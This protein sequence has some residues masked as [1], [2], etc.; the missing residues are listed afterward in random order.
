V[1]IDVVPDDEL[2]RDALLDRLRVSEQKRALAEAQLAL[3][4]VAKAPTWLPTDG[5][6]A[7][8]ADQLRDMAP[9]IDVLFQTAAVAM[10]LIAGDSMILRANQVAADTWGHP[11][12]DLH[13]TRTID[14]TIEEDT[15]DTRERFAHSERG[16]FQL[17][18]YRRGDGTPFRALAMGWPL[19]DDDGEV[20]CLIGVAIPLDRLGASPSILAEMKAAAASGPGITTPA[21]DD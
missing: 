14:L 4:K 3:S 9:A 21:E 15:V 13:G 12:A 6:G 19:K 20:V 2:D 17:K 11:L 10:L 16:Q 5:R 7:A 1:S 18:T 8:A